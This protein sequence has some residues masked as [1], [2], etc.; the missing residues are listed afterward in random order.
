[1]ISLILM[2]LVKRI[3]TIICDIAEIEAGFS[4]PGAWPGYNLAQQGRL[5]AVSTRLAYENVG[6]SAHHYQARR[7]GKQ[8]AILGVAHMAM[9][10]RSQVLCQCGVW[11]AN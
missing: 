3:F 7:T 2:C 10:Y 11:W 4:M 6:L 5:A 1:V 8:A 9:A